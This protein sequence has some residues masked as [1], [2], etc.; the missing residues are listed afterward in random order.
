MVI[1]QHLIGHD[2]HTGW[3][4]KSKFDN[5]VC[6]M[7]DLLKVMRFDKCKYLVGSTHGQLIRRLSLSDFD[8]L[9]QSFF[10]F[11]RVHMIV[12]FSGHEVKMSQCFAKNP[13]WIQIKFQFLTELSFSSKKMKFYDQF[14]FIP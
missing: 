14:H 2:L 8:F 1:F 13:T 11:L 3:A 7:F 10:L 5:K 9:N 6:S 12:K 4:Y